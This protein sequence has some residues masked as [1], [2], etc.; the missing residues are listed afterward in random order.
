MKYLQQMVSVYRKDGCHAFT[1]NQFG[2]AVKVIAKNSDDINAAFEEVQPVV[3]T[4]TG[5]TIHID[6]EDDKEDRPI[7]FGGPFKGSLDAPFKITSYEMI[8]GPI[9]S[10]EWTI[11]CIIS[12]EVAPKQFVFMMLCQRGDSEMRFIKSNSE[13]RIVQMLI[14][15][16]N[17]KKTGVLHTKERIKIGGGDSKHTRTIRQ[18]V[19]VSNTSTPPKSESVGV[20]RNIDWSHR[21]IV[22]G[23][24]RTLS[25]PVSRGK[26]RGG[27]YT[28]SGFTWVTEHEK[29]A[30]TPLVKKTMIVS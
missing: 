19:Y 13:G 24:W 26:D 20:P 30:E 14:D 6:K 8:D 17:T 1:N 16:L 21:W 5:S 15:R 29:G 11:W 3:F 4:P 18:V 23:H 12:E 22:R 7:D 28:V 9:T 25:D 2:Q 27:E 10:G